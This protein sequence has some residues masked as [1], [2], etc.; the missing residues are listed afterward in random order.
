MT[1]ELFRIKLTFFSLCFLSTQPRIRQTSIN[2]AAAA[3][4]CGNILSP[5]CR[6]LV[7]NLVSHGLSM[8]PVCKKR[9]VP[10]AFNSHNTKYVGRLGKK[11]KNKKQLFQKKWRLPSDQHMRACALFSWLHCCGENIWVKT[12]FSGAA[13][14]CITGARIVRSGYTVNQ[15]F[16]QFSHLAFTVYPLEHCM[17]PSS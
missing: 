9:S 17:C 7:N 8:R 16:L 5:V 13:K 11:S 1:G 15:F 10:P 4:K 2:R 12:R 3:G 14:G 6:V